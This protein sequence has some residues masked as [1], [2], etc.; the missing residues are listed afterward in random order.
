MARALPTGIVRTAT[1]YR[2]FVWVPWPGYPKGRIRSKRFTRTA[3][4]EPTQKEMEAWRE[5]RRVDARRKK[6]DDPVP[7]GE[8]F[9]ADADR[10]LT[11][12]QGM[13][14]FKD[15]RRHIREWAALFGERPRAEIQAHEIRAQRDQWLTVG[16]K[17]VLVKPPTGKARWEVHAVPLSASTVNQKLRALENLYTLLGGRDGYNP[18]REVDEAEPPEELPRGETFALAYEIL[19]HMPDVTRST[20]DQARE[21]GSLSR[22]RFETMLMTG[23]PPK[24]LGRLQPEHVNWDAL[25]VTPPKRAKGRRARRA[26]ARRKVKPRQLMP[27]AVPVLRRFFALQANRPFSATSLGRSVKRAIRTANKARVPRGL[28]PIPETLSVYDLTRHTFGTEVFRLT[29]NLLLVKDLLG[30]ATL[31][32]SER[33]AQRAIQEHQ[34]VSVG[35]LSRVARRAA[36]APA[37]PRRGGKGAGKVSPQKRSGRVRTRRR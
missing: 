19:A 27:A 26:R 18:V 3:T 23:L 4:Y 30:H 12:V 8:G 34:V 10:Y 9:L 1:G 36:R 25:T 20:K 14:G 33:Y 13:V 6:G 22:V 15:R 24:Q 7:I 29:K 32:Q 37:A 2:V 5:D 21:A 28:P 35:R 31:E 17:H 11:S 16:P